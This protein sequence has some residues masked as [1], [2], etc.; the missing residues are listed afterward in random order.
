ME[1][2]FLA[3][4]NH[5]LF[6]RL[7]E[8]FFLTNPSSELL[9]KDFLFSRNSLLYLRVLSILPKPFLIC[10]ETISYRQT[11]FLLV[12]PQCLASGNHFFPL[13]QIFLKKFFIPASGNTF[14]SPEEQVSFYLELFSLPVGNV[15]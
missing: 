5:K 15:T 11:L 7:V 14:F 1:T 10:M 12:D 3:S 13:T 8:T 4:T 9:Q 6:F 2:G